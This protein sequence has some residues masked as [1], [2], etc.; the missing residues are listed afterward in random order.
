VTTSTST[1]QPL[2]DTF[3]VTGIV[4]DGAAPVEGAIVMQAGGE[5]AFTTGPDGTFSIEMTTAIPGAPAAVATKIGYR[6]KGVEIL[7]L[8]EEGVVLEL[9]FVSPPDNESYVYGDPGPG[10]ANSSTEYCDHCHTTFVKQFRASAHARSAKDP[11]VQDLY[12]G[13]TSAAADAAA[14]ASIGGVWRSGLV[15]GTAGDVADKC[16]AGGGVLPDLNPT[17]GAPGEA[18]CD[19]P[20]IAPAK[21]PSAFGRCADCHA[22]GILGKAGGRDLHDAVGT[23]FDA[24]NHCDVCHKARDVNLGAPSG[25]AGAL[26]LQRPRE[27]QSDDPNAKIKQVMFGPLP[28][29]PNEFMGGSYQPV[30]T[31]SDLCGACHDHRQPALLPGSALDPARWPD[32]LPVLDT[33]SEWKASSFNTPG[34]PCQFC[35]MPPDDTGLKSSLDVTNEDNASIAFGYLRSPERIRKHIFRGPLQ[36]APR[37]IDSA[38]NLVLGA[39]VGAGGGT[40]EVTATVTVQNVLAGHAIPTGEPMRSLVLVVRA[41]GCGQTWSAS[42]GATIRD[43]AG[44]LASGIVGAGVSAN[45]QVLAWALGAAAAKPGMRVRAARPT[46]VFDDYAGVGFF[47]DPALLPEDKGL[48]IFAPAGEATVV[49][50]ANGE[51]TLDA[52]LALSPGD[53]VHLG[54][55]LPASLDDGAPSLAIAGAAG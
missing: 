8:P 9:L 44:S 39:S 30:F 43:G 51:I 34:T 42:G 36:G 31:K 6:T 40:P 26:V 41:E 3:I 14:C 53:V 55:A 28:D 11:L 15:P 16:Y 29:V 17:C 20:S 1:G 10:D 12:A 23:A 27:K 25:V 50:A 54:D 2:P 32:G 4:T 13:V 52:A 37:L 35:H 5:P 46:G 7:A 48:E 22:P 49:S 47:A 21:E 18:A 45:G 33:Y 24:G 19:D 38:I